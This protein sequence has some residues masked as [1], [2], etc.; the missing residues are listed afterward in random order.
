MCYYS[1]HPCRNL[2][3]T[4]PAYGLRIQYHY[5]WIVE[6]TSYPTGAGGVVITSFYLSDARNGLPFF[7][8][9]VD[10]LTKE[11]PHEHTVN[12]NKYLSKSFENK[13]STGF[14]NI[15]F[16]EHNTN[17]TLAG[18]PA[19]TIV[20]TYTNPVYGER[21]SIEIGTII[22]NKGYFVDYTTAKTK[23][24]N[25]LP[26]AQKMIKSFEIIKSTTEVKNCCWIWIYVPY[27]AN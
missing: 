20:W 1:Y 10:N 25:Y 11:F 22:G 21:K 27:V 23:F 5:N 6:G 13:N 17:N 16:L 24:Q 3:Y 12:I 18:N 15:R 4:N 9:G 19:Y 7:R 14:P 26:L 8:I 2:I